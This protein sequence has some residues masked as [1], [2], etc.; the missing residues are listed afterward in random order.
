V[1]IN[2]KLNAPQGAFAPQNVFLQVIGIDPIL[3]GLS[4]KMKLGVFCF[5]NLIIT[6]KWKQQFKSKVEKFNPNVHILFQ[7][8]KTND[9]SQKDSPN[10]KD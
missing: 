5:I 1:T 9:V 2:Q 8:P 10:V 7:S 3:H 4:C 6:Y